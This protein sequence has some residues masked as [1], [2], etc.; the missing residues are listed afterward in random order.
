MPKVARVSELI[1]SHHTQI[2][3]S[4]G[5]SCSIICGRDIP[6][7]NS[8]PVHGVQLVDADRRHNLPEHV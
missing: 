1:N 3:L 4:S 6:V 8:K 2:L 7:G 5:A